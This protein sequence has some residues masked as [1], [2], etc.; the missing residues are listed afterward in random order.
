[1]RKKEKKVLERITNIEN[2][3][4]ASEMLPQSTIQ[5]KTEIEGREALIDSQIIKLQKLQNVQ[6]SDWIII[7]NWANYYA[8]VFKYEC[9][10][11]NFNKFL[12]RAIR[13]AFIYGSIGVW[14]NNGT[15]E[16][17]GYQ[18]LNS[19]F[20][21]IFVIEEDDVDNYWKNKKIPLK[22]I[23]KVKSDEIIFYKFNSLGWTAFAYL[24]PVIKMEKM[25]QKA[26]YNQIMVLP[27]RI[28]ND[29]TIHDNNFKAA[30]SFVD[31]NSPIIT[32]IEG[33]VDTFQG[34]NLTTSTTDLLNTV[35]YAKNWY[36]EVLGRRTNSEFKKTHSLDSE[37]ETAEKQFTILERDRY[38]HLKEFL[39][40]FSDLFDETVYLENE[41]GELVDCK[42][43]EKIK[44]EK[45]EIQNDF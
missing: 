29:K 17:V 11:K 20:Y 8:N 9:E 35:E 13:S 32:R 41:I 10:R 26:L 27:T 38:L 2:R 23:K 30:Q 40:D 19:D 6:W 16:L 1:M 4:N 18:K 44:E 37:L 25:V 24:K 5:L 21:N 39:K 34:L 22:N 3:L 33:G 31:F 28:I 14:N 15:P 42:E 45:E 7:N 43:R 12:N 36:Y